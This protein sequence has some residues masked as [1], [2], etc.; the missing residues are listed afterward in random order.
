[1]IGLIAG[2][3]VVNHSQPSAAGLPAPVRRT[4]LVTVAA[5]GSNSPDLDLLF[6][7]SGAENN[8]LRYALWHR[9]YT[10]TLIG[11]LALALLL[12]SAAEAWI[13]YKGLRPSRRDRALLLGTAVFTTALHLIMDYLNSYGVHPFWPMENRWTYGD[14]VFIVEPLYWAAAAPLFFLLRSLAARLLFAAALIAAVALGA[15]SGLVSATLCAVLSLS[16]VLLLA[17]GARVSAR[18]A[19]RVSV[20]ACLGVTLG[21]VLAGQFAAHRVEAL[22]RS[23]F[24][25]DRMLDHVITPLPVNPFCW[26]VL[27]LETRGERY[28]VRHAILAIAPRVINAAQCPSL[29]TEQHT[30]TLAAVSAADSGAVHW[31]GEFSMSRTELMTL[32]AENCN[33]AAFMR[34]ARVPFVADPGPTPIMGD[35][36]FDRG[37]ERAGFE[38]PLASKGS[39][40]GAGTDCGRAAPW[41]APRADLLR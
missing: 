29:A 40:P 13:Y 30:A 18:T 25:T 7:F 1:M 21:F 14:S 36:R 35:L 6:T 33:A 12:Y 10:H 34:F 24:A 20:A 22:A 39:S 23:T 17:I 3:A 11:C 8:H 38:V 5:V 15:A 31:L 19:S 32:V 2:E 9:G 4:L 16:I 41:M 37:K 27:L 26:D 28:L